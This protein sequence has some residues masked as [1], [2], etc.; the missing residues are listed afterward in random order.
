[1]NLIKNTY[2]Y[3]IDSTQIKKLE[4]DSIL[5]HEL[6]YIV[7]DSS[8]IYFSRED[9]AVQ[10]ETKLYEDQDG[11]DG[12]KKPYTLEKDDG[13]F[14]SLLICFILFVSLYKGGVAFLKKSSHI[15]FGSLSNSNLAN[16][17]TTS[18]FWFN[19]FL[20]F[21]T[22]LLT[23]IIL[24]DLFLEVDRY[25]I[26]HHS[27]FTISLFML[28]ISA[29][30]AIKYFIYN[31]LGYFFNSKEKIKVWLKCYF[32]ILEILGITAFIPVLMLVYSQNFH[33]ELLIVLLI[34][35]IL[36][37]LILFYRLTVFFLNDNVN[38]L[39]LIAYL[40]SVEI[41][42]YIILYR[43]LIYQYKIDIISL[44]WH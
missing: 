40:C 23:S 38:L 13:V 12:I 26:L 5:G 44:L 14:A 17:T 3:P 34:L 31:I 29:F 25:P 24:F 43:V 20:L 4:K 37:Q 8:S 16:E 32:L 33:Q 7:K 39:F 11:Y 27:F 6:Y 36:S 35:F 42:P 30:L 1:M 41:I 28:T 15:L 2:P 9:L 22:V 19:F 10:Y 18:D 21:Q